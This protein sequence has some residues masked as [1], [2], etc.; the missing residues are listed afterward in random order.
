MAT[1]WS[2]ES[3]ELTFEAKSRYHRQIMIESIGEKGQMRLLRSSVFICGCG[4]LG[5]AVA[6]MLVRAGIGAVRI[7]D[8]DY[9]QLSNLHRQTLFTEND[10]RLKRLKVQAGQDSLAAANSTVLIEGIVDRFSSANAEKMILNPFDADKKVDVLIDGT[11][12]FSTRFLLNQIAVQYNIPFISAGVCG[13]TGQFLTIFPGQTPCLACLIGNDE[14]DQYNKSSQNGQFVETGN[15]LSGSF[16]N[17]VSQSDFVNDN[18]ID[19]LS[20]LFPILPPIVQLMAAL[21]ASAAIKILSGNREAVSK[22]LISIDLWKNQC[23]S[24]DLASLV[25]KEDCPVCHRKMDERMSQQNVDSE[26]NS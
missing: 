11:D 20:N 8:S 6:E 5:G 23:R 24:L 4:A 16:Q 2:K 17:P 1:N 12:N 22:K 3:E 10:A 25:Q 13:T 26:A 19:S 15:D 18:D 21:E 14:K 7:I 9:V